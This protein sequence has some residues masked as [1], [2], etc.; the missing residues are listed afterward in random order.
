MGKNVLCL[1]VYLQSADRQFKVP[2]A[3]ITLRNIT[4]FNGKL[5]LVAQL[6]RSVQDRNV[7]ACLAILTISRT[8]T[9]DRSVHNLCR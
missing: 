1:P 9:A 3:F 8:H 5:K 6:E 4:G 2:F 7:F